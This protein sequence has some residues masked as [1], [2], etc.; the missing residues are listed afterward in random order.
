MIRYVDVVHCWFSFGFHAMAVLAAEGTSSPTFFNRVDRNLSCMSNW[1]LYRDFAG[2]LLMVQVLWTLFLLENRCKDA[3]AYRSDGG[4]RFCPRHVQRSVGERGRYGQ[5]LPPRRQPFSYRFPNNKVLAFVC[6]KDL[7]RTKSPIVS[8]ISGLF[9]VLVLEL[10]LP[11][12]NAGIMCCQRGYWT[13]CSMRWKS[14]HRIQT[15]AILHRVRFAIL[16]LT[17]RLPLSIFDVGVAH[18][19]TVNWIIPDTL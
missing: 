19:H 15:S 8:F 17:V 16:Q 4:D 5:H 6:Y 14:I 1:A 10:L 13:L 2:E 11:Q 9:C 7:I 18:Q 12:P 3:R